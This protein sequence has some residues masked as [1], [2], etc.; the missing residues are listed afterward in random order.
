MTEQKPIQESIERLQAMRREIEQRIQAA[1]AAEAARQ[2]EAARLTAV[3][4]PG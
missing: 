2:A 1:R 3:K 4:K